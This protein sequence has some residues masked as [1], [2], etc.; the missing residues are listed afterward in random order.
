M[1]DPTINADE[2]D[3]LLKQLDGSILT[4]H[5]Y[6]GHTQYNCFKGVIDGN[7]KNHTVAHR[8]AK[9]RADINDQ[10]EADKHFAAASHHHYLQHMTPKTT[11]IMIKITKILNSKGIFVIF[12]SAAQATWSRLLR[13]I[14]GGFIQIPEEIMTNPSLADFRQDFG[15]ASPDLSKNPTIMDILGKKLN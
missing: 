12:E 7:K 9:F 13:H 6:T 4:E 15:L 10:N 2:I 14:R 5:N 1:D 3:K 11:L 8:N